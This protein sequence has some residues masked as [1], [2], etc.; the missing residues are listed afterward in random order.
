MG[1]LSRKLRN[2]GTADG[3]IEGIAHWCPGCKQAHAIYT[4][5]LGGPTW[6]WD[7]NAD[8]PTCKPS[9]RCFTRYD[10]DHNLL[11]NGGERTLCHYV[12]TAGV[13]NYCGDCG[14]HGLSNQQVP[15]PDFPESWG[16]FE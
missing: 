8:A 6:E 4:K 1:T 13:I 5:N 7:G 9:V 15:L 16:G 3:S 14:D 12:L 10:D 11:P 2:F